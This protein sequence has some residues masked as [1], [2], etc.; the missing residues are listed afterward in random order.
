[1]KKFIDDDFQFAASQYKLLS[2][3]LPADKMP[4][5]F[6][7]GELKTS[8]VDWW[9][10]GFYPGS[11][12]LIY[13]H[14]GDA[15]IKTEAEKRLVLEEKVKRYTGNHDIGFMIFCS[16]GN[17]YRITGDPKYRVGR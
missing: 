7:N 13:E 3:S 15:A 17:A 4:K 16:F 5:T 10:S 14:T 9:T 2:Q 6:E 1:M 8:G 12:W 11:L